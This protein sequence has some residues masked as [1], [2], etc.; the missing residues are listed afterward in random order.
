MKTLESIHFFLKKNLSSFVENVCIA[1]NLKNT[2][3]KKK[4]NKTVDV[5]DEMINRVDWSD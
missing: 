1:E 5:M 4:H 2:H 3:T